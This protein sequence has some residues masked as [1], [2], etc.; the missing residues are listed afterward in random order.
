MR[1]SNTFTYK[2]FTGSVEIRKGRLCGKVL[3]TEDNIT[4]SASNLE[5][6][7]KAFEHEVEKNGRESAD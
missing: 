3:N 5:K 2:G 1:C 4:Y 7:K 6:L